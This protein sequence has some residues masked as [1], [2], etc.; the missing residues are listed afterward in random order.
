VRDITERVVAT[1]T[2]IKQKE[3]SE[4]IINT[5][6]AIIVGLDNNHLI[7][8]FN[9]GAEEITGYKRENV[10]G[11]DWFKI[12]FPP[13]ILDEMHQV[14]ISSWGKSAHSYIN[15]IRIKNGVERIISWQTT[16]FY[17][18]DVNDQ[19]MISIG[20]DI[21]DRKQMEQTISKERILLKAIIDN[22]PVFL[23]Q[24]DPNTNMLYLNKMFEN[25]I[26]W[27]TE[28]VKDIDMM[29]EVYPDP[30][31]RKQAH[32][33]MQE[34]STEWR[35]FRVQSKSGKI[36]DSEWSNIRLDDGTQ[37][38]IG[39]DITERKLAEKS[40]KESEEKFRNYVETSQD[41]IWEC[42]DKGRFNYLNPAWEG[43]T[44]YK[45]SEMIG[46]PFADFTIP[47]EVES[48]S[49][50]FA[51]HLER[52]FV[53][54]FPSTYISKNGSEISLIFNAIPLKDAKN[55]IIGTQGS[56]Y[57]ITERE[58]AEQEKNLLFEQLKTANKRLEAL[59]RELIQSQEEERKRIAQELHDELG[60]ALTAITLDLN[61]IERDLGQ[62]IPQ[63]IRKR[64]AG[65]R[66]IADEL[67]QKASDLALDLRPSLLDDLGLAP[68]LT[69]YVDRFSQRAEIEVKFEVIGREKR[70]SPEIETAFYRITQEALTNVARHARAKNVQMVLEL[71]PKMVKV[72]IEDDGKGFDLNKLRKSQS[73][74]Q[75]LGLIGIQERVSLLGGRLEI[76][77]NP[78]EGTRIEIEIP[79]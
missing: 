56:A 17:D 42:D 73:L 18:K 20:E 19:L 68:T 15:P 27:K 24:Y 1:K 40:L 72:I 11:K 74:S 12:F 41:L 57:D 78:G 71:R 14:W 6:N 60:Q 67:D 8:L 59:S 7:R 46:K 28:E 49:A 47:E 39:I 69:W 38:G 77:S 79:L 22:I 2:L 30:D 53:K 75:G 61:I 25:T 64:L 54:G 52:G 9:R 44:G 16:G 63:G 37:I 23:T 34:A 45:L 10:L 70:L 32:D 3:F 62:E 29:A 55:N 35:E 76:H 36:I 58:Q 21:T 66:A 31:Y 51:K 5:S 4:K 26:G 48:N 65:T 33:Y 43:V 13:E 50:E